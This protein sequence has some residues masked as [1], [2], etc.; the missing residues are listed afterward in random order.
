M[1]TENLLKEFKG[2]M[3]IFHEGEDDNL[4]LL[5]SL[6]IAFVEEKCG[7][8]NINGNENIDKRATELVFE[9]TRYT[10]NDALEYFEDNFLS[11]IISLSIEMVG[12][13]DASI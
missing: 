3:H 5:L 8:F 7:K 13:E 12:D 6:S 10:Y 4:K 1:V 2:R 9:R 11:E